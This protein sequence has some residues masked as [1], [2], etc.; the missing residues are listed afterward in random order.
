MSINSW[1]K[2]HCAYKEVK[3]ALNHKMENFRSKTCHIRHQKSIFWQ[4]LSDSPMF[5]FSFFEEVFCFPIEI[6]SSSMLSTALRSMEV[7]WSLKRQQTTLQTIFETKL[8]ECADCAGIT[9]WLLFCLGFLF[10][11]DECLFCYKISVLW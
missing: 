7:E 1:G 4:I 11:V 5:F 10:V 6:T 3:S 9:L 8:L 2:P